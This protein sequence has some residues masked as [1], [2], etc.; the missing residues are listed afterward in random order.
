[1]PR[2]W[3]GPLFLV[4]VINLAANDLYN[5]HRP[6]SLDAVRGQDH[7][8]RILSSQVRKGT[9]AHA[10]VFCGPAGTGKT[11]MAR[12]LAAML[13]C[14]DGPKVEFLQDDAFVKSIL[15]G[16]CLCDVYE[17]D[18]ATQNGID[19]VRILRD[20]AVLNPLEARYKIYILDESH[21]LSGQ[22]WDGLL[23]I[24]EEPPPH[25]KFIFCTTEPRKIP[26][27]II[28]RC[29]VLDF[30]PLPVQA[31]MEELRSVA[32][33]EGIQADDD[34]IRLLACSSGGSMRQALSW[35]EEASSEGR[36]TAEAASAAAG[37]TPRSKARDFVLAVVKQ[38]FMD[39]LAASS[40]VLGQGGAADKFLAE[41]A[42]FC[43]DVLVYGVGGYDWA[44]LGYSPKE[45]EDL[46]S[47]KA[48]LKEKVK[49]PR[50]LV[51]RWI[52][53]LNEYHS[54][55]IFNMQAQFQVDTAFVEMLVDYKS[56]LK[57]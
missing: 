31:I 55:S 23:K 57:S 28:T 18:A 15:S 7:V 4:E 8:K 20:Q 39:G 47:A 2:P 12:I 51:L 5:R 16:R 33:K 14:E 13:N 36:M 6:R 22:A 44:A 29:M 26:D 21:R 3:R 11:T 35:L 10:Y 50:M 41:V 1:L 9:T 27:T 42:G 37:A 43:H 49:D 19:Q 54:M 56:A 17:Q 48:L 34:A 38:E 53:A 52:R 45:I 30:K 40:S 46:A 25:V 32:S 24:V